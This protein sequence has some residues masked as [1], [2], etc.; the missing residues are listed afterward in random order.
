MRK[1]NF[2]VLLLYLSIG[3]VIAQEENTYEGIAKSV[4]NFRETPASDGNLIRQLP[5]NSLLYILSR[6]QENGYLE[7]IDIQ[8]GKVGWAYANAVSITKTIPIEKG[9]NF[10]ESY[11][12]GV[13]K[14]KVEIKNDTKL[15]I[16]L[17][18]AGT[19]NQ[20]KPNE[21][22]SLHVSPGRHKYHASAMGVYPSSGY[23]DFKGAHTYTWKFYISTIEVPKY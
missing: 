17:Q 4:I 15:V 7:V 22:L 18:I 16:T 6:K 20:I 13:V 5:P 9:D 2:I 19:I 3:H 14:S 1:L 12:K 23:D 21:V 11:T 10:T 8:T